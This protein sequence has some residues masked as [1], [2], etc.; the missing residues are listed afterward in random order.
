MLSVWDPFADL[1]RIQ[2]ELEKNFFGA[3]NRPAD[4]APPVDVYEDENSLVLRAELPGVKR[5]DIDIQVDGNVLTLKG[6]RK[7]EAEQQGRRYHRIERS[8]GTF[9][10]QFQIPTGVDS[11]QIDA[12]LVDGTLTLRLPKKP[13]QKARKIEV[14]AG[15]N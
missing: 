13:E 11:S 9:V 4:F 3:R 1:N 15:G 10:R 2:R 8:Y 6:E 12:Q 7:L 14:K 5:E